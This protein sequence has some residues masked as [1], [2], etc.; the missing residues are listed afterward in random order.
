MAIQ[1]RNL[2]HNSQP[3][4]PRDAGAKAEPQAVAGCAA[5]SP[6]APPTPAAQAPSTT[7]GAA[8]TLATGPEHGGE[9]P[10]T[11]APAE[12]AHGAFPDAAR[13]GPPSAP[14]AP[15]SPAKDRMPSDQ[16]L[17][18]S[19]FSDALRD[20]RDGIPMLRLI[21]QELL[22]EYRTLRANFYERDVLRPVFLAVIAAIDRL[23]DL[24]R[25]IRREER[26]RP[27]RSTRGN[28]KTTELECR[29]ELCVEDMHACLAQFGV[30]WYRTPQDRFSPRWQHLADAV[31]TTRRT[32]HGRLAERI[33]PGYCRDKWIIRPE[34]VRVYVYCETPSQTKG[35][36]PCQTS[37]P[38][39][40]VSTVVP[41]E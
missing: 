8:A 2:D 28:A 37:S 34:S 18:E 21:S 24:L 36:N 30:R 11:T 32:D 23:S 40:P 4:V 31:P 3:F 12:E 1:P 10:P 39:Q 41:A 17:T 6:P 5:E 14:S 9:T 25:Q 33:S 20:I 15:R 16:P 35:T 26:R 29:L 13:P 22:T 38:D 27:R 7:P 19:E